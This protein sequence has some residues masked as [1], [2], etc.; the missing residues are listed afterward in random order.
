VRGKPVS[1]A[2]VLPNL[3]RGGT[4]RHVLDLASRLDR[5]RY[6]PFVMT[7]AGGGP[8]Q[9]DLEARG[10]PVHVLEYPGM[11]LRSGLAGPP[12]RQAVSFFAAFRRILRSEATE[13]VHAYLP[14]GNVLGMA[15]AL[16]AGVRVRIVS[17]R[18]LCRYKEGHPLFSA[19]E[20]LANLAAHAVM[21]N[22]RAVAEEVRRTERFAARKMFLVYNGVEIEAGLYEPAR[23][24]EELGLPA[25]AR[26][27]TYVANLREDKAHL[28][29]VE[30]AAAVAAAVPQVR[31]LF[32]GAEGREAPAVRRRI[33]ELGLSNRVLLAGPRSHVGAILGAS[34]V[35]A[36]PGEQEG[37]SNA[38]L[39]AM[40]AARPVVASR[41]GGNPEAVVHGETGFLAPPGD[42]R[43]FAG[44]ILRLLRDPDLARAM[45]EAGRKRAARFFSM[46]AMVGAVQR[47]YDELLE[48]RP[49]SCRP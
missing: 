41:A 26:L 27:V 49:L 28:C 39:E 29:L 25:G 31:F 2:Y 4:E 3:E 43:A 47:S 33:A 38:I 37:F 12:F 14:A 7:T 16:G 18:A 9:A 24:P 46:D 13:I 34:A 45:G 30:A 6:R 44:A 5:T 40:A 48:G 21:V 17:K 23:P 32:V 11:G 15:A 42:A 1:V 35:V 19:L 20:D 22:S 36:H 8:L 10:I